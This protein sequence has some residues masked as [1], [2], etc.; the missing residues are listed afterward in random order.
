MSQKTTSLAA[1]KINL[2]LHIVGKRTD[3]YHNL[4]SLVVFADIADQLTATPIAGPDHLEVNG[5][6]AHNLEPGSSNLVLKAME[7]VR[8]R[9]SDKVAGGLEL[10]L[11]K[12]LPIASGLG[13]GSADAA[14][15]LR[16]A[17]S[18]WPEISLPQMQ[19][20]ALSLGA[21][22]PMCL[23]QDSARVQ[24]IGE[25]ITPVGNMPD[26]ALVLVNPLKKISTP[27]VFARLTNTE[28]SAMAF[29]NGGWLDFADLMEFLSTTRNDLTNAAI[30]MVPQ[31][32][33]IQQAM[34][35]QVNCG[36]ARM[37]GSGATVFGL[38]EYSEDAEVAATNLRNAYPEYWIQS[39]QILRGN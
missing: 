21:D 36:F 22:V 20:I 5:P 13:G 14:A 37:S 35:A 2:T 33:D 32:G 16:L 30:S 27:D 23:H 8:S 18:N 12:C 4:D 39:G 15:A 26:M 11:T 31:I 9:H 17:R 38:F 19:E 24:G 25:H 1:A 34:L 28:N 6:F 29:F 10:K 3:G 7:M